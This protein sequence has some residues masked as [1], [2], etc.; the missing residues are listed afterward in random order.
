MIRIENCHK[1]DMMDRKNL[2]AAECDPGDTVIFETMDCADGAVSRQGVRDYSRE[3]LH[4]PATG[5]LFVR[6]AHPGDVLK[7]RILNIRMADWGF[8]G[9]G[10]GCD[11]FKAIQGDYQFRV[12]DISDGTVIVDGYDISS[13]KTDINKMRENV[14]MVFYLRKI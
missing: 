11:C 6:G 5:P 10:F 7:V 13:K 1:I 14:G 8:M 9:T 3:Y 2:P 12:F 4:N